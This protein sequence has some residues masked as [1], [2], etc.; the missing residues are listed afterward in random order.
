MLDGGRCRHKCWTRV[1]TV[2]CEGIWR[3]TRE[4]EQQE[5][6][7]VSGDR[8][9]L[10]RGSATVTPSRGSSWTQPGRT[11]LITSFTNAFSQFAADETPFRS[12]QWNVLQVRRRV[13]RVNRMAHFTVERL[14]CLLVLFFRCCYSFAAITPFALKSL[15]QRSGEL[16]FRLVDQW[17]CPQMISD[18]LHPS[19]VHKPSTNLQDIARDF[20]TWSWQTRPFSMEEVRSAAFGTRQVFGNLLCNPK[21]YCHRSQCPWCLSINASR[22]WRTLK[23]SGL[24]V[25]FTNRVICGAGLH[26]TLAFHHFMRYK[27]CVIWLIFFT[28]PTG[29]FFL[30]TGTSSH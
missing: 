2:G 29:H 30:L 19:S 12:P 23:T 16:I 24:S 7:A 21:R 13:S 11:D 4:K 14:I 28:S 1:K 5:S 10:K 6:S 17:E 26:S 22:Q 8:P 25:V 20:P 18:L 3:L 15:K 27:E 9:V